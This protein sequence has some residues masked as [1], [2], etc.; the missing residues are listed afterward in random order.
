V[1]N[2]LVES[3][4][5]IHLKTGKTLRTDVEIMTAFKS[6][7]EI[8]DIKNGILNDPTSI[9]SV[10]VNENFVIVPM[11]SVDYLEFDVTYVGDPVDP[12]LTQQVDNAK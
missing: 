11:L 3:S 10:S 7:K 2:N 6:R 9:L 8:L 1:T 5:R 4:I 12:R